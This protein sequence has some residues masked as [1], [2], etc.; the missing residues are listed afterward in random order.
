MGELL[1]EVMDMRVVCSAVLEDDRQ[2]ENLCQC[3][4]IL[5]GT[6]CISGNTVCVEYSGSETTVDKYI[7]LFAQFPT[8]EIHSFS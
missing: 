4:N 1:K 8:H 5:G 7:E 6:P 2:R 3:V